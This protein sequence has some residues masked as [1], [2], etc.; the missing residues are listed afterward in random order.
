MKEWDQLTPEARPRQACYTT[1]RKLTRLKCLLIIEAIG[2]W[3][4]ISPNLKITA[5]FIDFKV[6]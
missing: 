2:D 4:D 1:L 5:T 6:E 3:R